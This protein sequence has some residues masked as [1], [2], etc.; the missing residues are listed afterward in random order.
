MSAKV[1]YFLL[2]SEAE[3]V[4]SIAALDPRAAAAHEGLSRLHAE[5]A[6]AG[7]SD[8]AEP[9]PGPNRQGLPSVR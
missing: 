2:R 9:Q 8:R 5:R 7:L 4:R 3:A 6:I 1:D